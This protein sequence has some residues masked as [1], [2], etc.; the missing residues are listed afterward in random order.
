MVMR[1]LRRNV[2]LIGLAAALAITGCEAARKP[3]AIE[4]NE[5][6]TTYSNPFQQLDQEW[7]DYG[8]GDPFVM[9]HNGRYYLY[10]STKDHRVGIKAWESDDLVNWRYAGL[11][12]EDLVSTGAY[13][14]EVVYWNGYF[15]LYTSPAGRGHYVYR[16]ESPT[17]PFERI[18][19][20]LGMSID[21]SVFI[22]DDGSWT[23][24]HAGTEGIVGVPMDGS[25]SFGLGSTIDGAFLGHWTEGSM[26][27]KRAGTYYMTFTGN[28]VFS[29]GY[30]IQ[31]AVAKDSPTGPYT[32]PANNPIV[33]STDPEFNGLGHSSTVMGPD[34]DS[35]YLVYHNLIGRSA[36]GPP[37]R[38]MNI[39]RLV[40]NGDRM[41][42]LGPSR[43]DQPVPARPDFEARLDEGRE[44]WETISLDS[45]SLLIGDKASSERFTAE[46]NIRLPEAPASDTRI[47][48]VFGYKDDSHYGI[49]ELNPAEGRLSL[50]V[51]SGGNREVVGEAELAPD[52]D[53][54]KLHTIRVERGDHGLRVYIDGLLKLESD[55]GSFGAGR[56]G[57]FSQGASEEP[58]Y[59]YT[60]FSNHVDG[61]SDYEAAKFL[62]GTIQ[63]VHY[64][65]GENRGFAVKSQT[66]EGSE[67]RNADGTDIALAGDGSYRVALTD[68]G[69]WLR[70]IVNVS[71]AGTYSFEPTVAAGL[72]ESTVELLVDDQSAGKFTLDAGQFA[73]AEEWAKLRA[74]SIELKKGIHT[75]AVKLLSGN[76]ALKTLGFAVTESG[77]FSADA[78]LEEASAEDMHGE[79]T[80]EEGRYAGSPNGDSKMFA[81][82]KLWNDYVV[83]TSV[84]LGDDPSGSAGVL[85]RV[86]NESEF[87][88]QVR[89]SLM[90][91]NVAVTA[92][93]LEL[94]R[95]NYDDELVAAERVELPRGES[96][97]LRIEAKG[98]TIRVFVGDA[99]EAALAYDDPNAFLQ[100]KV[101]LRSFYAKDISLGDLN[102]QSIGK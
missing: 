84:T 71:E 37:V 50:A 18:T 88:D 102:V 78:V 16:S 6:T 39:D 52:T 91:Y 90:G 12:T 32:V 54:T 28:H 92:T 63:A 76:L 30:R 59:S 95:Y 40:F 5:Y 49:A 15:Y 67:V 73:E 82:N 60:A 89:D 31:Y 80:V 77:S 1:L 36:E 94:H 9:R 24:T 14:P 81:G 11:V 33:I 86:T 29:K 13:A 72:G 41:D 19:D 74:G 53:Y 101:G 65:Q 20:N 66:A 46:Y 17:G 45:G 48:A 100:G 7:E 3:E 57:Y 34:L 69:D 99:T 35:Y 51:V 79:W 87:R 42:V 75:I 22:D 10:V 64:L 25:A 4:M 38:K 58:S 44:G 21:G 27:I 97:K 96:T 2:G 70:Y 23:F 85:L 98:G 43:Y 26:I 8:N 83:E 62:P 56:I 93:K 68:K 61:S 55:Q 47:G